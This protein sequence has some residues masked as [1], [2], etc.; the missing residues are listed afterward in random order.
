[1]L[2]KLKLFCGI[3]LLFLGVL[4]LILPIMPGVPF[5][6]VSAAILGNEHPLIRPF[7]QRIDRWRGKRKEE[8]PEP[9]AKKTTLN[10][11]QITDNQQQP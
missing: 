2:P 3:G 1:M 5:L 9:E 7:K 10:R 6:L 11:E 4:G 8:A